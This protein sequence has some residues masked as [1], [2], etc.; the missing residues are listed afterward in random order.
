M[1]DSSTLQRA[2]EVLAT[3]RERA[4][5]GPWKVIDGVYSDDDGEYDASQIEGEHEMVAMD[6]QDLDCGAVP[7][8]GYADARL[9]VGT[10]GNTD[11]LDELDAMF[12]D[13]I[14]DAERGNG[15]SSRAERLAA[16]IIAADEQMTSIN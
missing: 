4:T 8:I 12:R 14:E 2:R 13:S 11:L 5:E 3:W 1:T 7:S 16:H 15:R 6:H 10:A 9:I